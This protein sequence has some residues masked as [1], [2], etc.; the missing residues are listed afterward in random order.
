MPRAFGRA[1]LFAMRSILAL[2]APTAV[3]AV[4]QVAAQL[5]ETWLA[6]RQGLPA[7]AG[8]AVVLPFALLMQM[9]S[10]GA[11]GGGV[12]SAI[13]RALGGGRRKE[14]AALVLHAALIALIAALCFAVPLAIF[15]RTVLGW[16]GG[17]QAAEAAAAYSAWLFGAG[18]LPAWLVNTLASVLRGGG[19]HALAARVLLGGWIVYPPVAWLLAEPLG[20]GLAGIGAAY[21]LVFW[22]AAIGMGVVVLRGGAGF[23]PTLRVTPS[24]EMFGRILSVGLVACAMVVVANLTTI[25]VTAQLAARGPAV[26]AAYGVSA[27]LEFLM[28]PVAFGIGSAVTALVG[29]AV[30]AGDWA[31]ARRLAWLGGVMAF[32]AA[33]ACGLVVALFPMPFARAFAANEEVAMI[34]ATA[35]AII[36]PAYAFFGLG[37]AMYFA[38]QGAGRMRWPVV[39]GLARFTLAVGGGALLVIPFG[40]E[41]QFLGVALGLTAYGVLTAVGVRPAVWR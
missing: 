36:G 19:R 1:L 14:A 4:V 23:T 17:S 6:A 25:L 30:G 12:V 37:M 24:A 28:I 11:M 16:V 34:A 38:A 18:A 35:L 9:M 15:P 8:W 26:V 40:L 5:F 21:A 29:R 20:M 39:A 10:G 33:G 2:A 27:R 13:A 41:G 32:V 3:V 31:Q 22:V 7:L